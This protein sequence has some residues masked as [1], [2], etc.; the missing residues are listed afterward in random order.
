MCGGLRLEVSI[1]HE[2]VLQE[3]DALV[4]DVF[5]GTMTR[6]RRAVK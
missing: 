4:A 6:N 5:M 1:S 3:E 2:R